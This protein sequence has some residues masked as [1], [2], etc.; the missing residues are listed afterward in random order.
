M[1]KYYKKLELDKVLDMLSNQAYSQQCKDT[2]AGIEPYDNIDTIREEIKKTNDAYILSVKFGSPRFYNIKN[3]TNS[4]M[5]SKSGALLSLR[6]LLDI[7]FVMREISG[8]CDWYKQ[9]SEIDTSLNYLFN[10]LSSHKNLEQRIS[11]AI[12]SEDEIADSA[13]PT[14]SSIRRRISR[15]GLYIREQLE[16]LVKTYSSSKYLQENIVTMRDGRFVIPV[17]TEYKKEVSG[18]VHDSSSSGATL[19]VEPMSVVEANNEIRVL[20]SQEQ[21]EIE[22]II[23]EFSDEISFIADDI[24]ISYDCA[25]ELELYF[26]KSNLGAKMKASTPNI[27]ND[28]KIILKKARHPLIDP[29]VVVPID[30]SLGHKYN[31][32][33]VTGPNTGG[34]TVA[35][36]TVGLLTLMAMCG[37]MIPVSDNSNVS[38]FK[39]ILADIGDEQSIE[40]SL[41]TFSSHMNNI[42]KI[43]EVADDESL[44]LL[45]ELGSGTDPIEGAAL[46]VSIINHLKDL[47]SKIVAT[48]HYQE[49]KIFALQTS[50]V[51]NASCEFDVATLKPTYRLITGVPGKSNAFAISSKL[52]LP[53]FIINNANELVSTEN[54]RFEEVIESLENSRLELESLKNNILLEERKSKLLS[55][56]LENQKKA[57]ELQKAKD[58]EIARQR[59]MSIVEEIRFKS[60]KLIDELDLLRKE[61]D[62]DDFSQKALQAKKQLNSQIDKL[63]DT[64][65]PVFERK[66]ENYKLPR[67]LKKGDMV[68]LIDIDKKASVLSLPDNSGTLY[69][70]A[71][72][73]KTKTNIKN[74][75]LIDEKVKVNGKSIT[76]TV[77]SNIERS[78]SMELDIRGMASDEGI[79]EVDRFIDNCILSGIQNV[80][81]IHGK[82]TGV[83][84]SN[85]HQFLRK[86][87]NVKFFRLGVYGEGESGVTIV[88]LQ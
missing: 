33:I 37:L 51:E 53:D 36:K 71:G 62:K 40:Q 83:L 64:A 47:G 74:V 23:R 45:D 24:K 15:Q 21:Q 68:L 20:Q 70:Q 14:L 55:E 76:R 9:C 84:R 78:G 88:E 57:F 25:I 59:A 66:S 49:V 58:L 35:I 44:V 13:S 4:L 72:V 34:K 28:G 7:A 18:L 56:E 39:N 81:I 19:F 26:A 10:A 2:I 77:K 29:K 50:G 80:T 22:R 63:Y 87:K 17:K 11:S 65:N 1:N 41:S 3:V 46:A 16:K 52:G 54:R 12:I 69:V 61:K 6:E 67:E 82:G 43:I 5:R 31:A 27:T 73:M 60:A 48:T 32:L 30:I 79:V 75:K 8:L 86:H 38:F 42:I 85:V